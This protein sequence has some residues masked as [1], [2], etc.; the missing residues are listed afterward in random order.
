MKKYLFYTEKRNYYEVEAKN[1]EEAE[2]K[3]DK[4][5]DLTDYWRDDLDEPQ[6]DFIFEEQ[7]E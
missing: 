2:K 5:D 1:E 3:L 6:T 4:C 7:T